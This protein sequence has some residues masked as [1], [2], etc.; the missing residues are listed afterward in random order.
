[1][2]MKR[3]RCLLRG[4][5]SVS[6]STNHSKTNHPTSL[7]LSQG[8]HEQHA[9]NVPLTFLTSISTL[10]FEESIIPFGLDLQFSAE[11]LEHVPEEQGFVD[12]N[13]ILRI[14]AESK[15]ELLVWFELLN[16][17]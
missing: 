13:G 8:E 7:I 4:S 14:W 9:L 11:V 5:V 6:R 12:K 2:I 3:Y 15:E 1:M 17:L 10:D 16:K